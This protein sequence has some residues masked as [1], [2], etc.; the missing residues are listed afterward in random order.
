MG[1]TMKSLTMVRI[2]DGKGGRD[3][4]NSNVYFCYNNNY[5]MMRTKTIQ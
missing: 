3:L 1:V 2:M 5:A 4:E